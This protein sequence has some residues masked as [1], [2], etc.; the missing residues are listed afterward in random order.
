MSGPF[1]MKGSPMKRNFGIGSPM[2]DEKEDKIAAK[3]AK[4]IAA[5][6]KKQAEINAKNAELKAAGIRI[7]YS[8]SQLD[9]QAKRD[10][11]STIVKNPSL[12]EYKYGD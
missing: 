2:K 3:D 9:E 7:G 11:T 8:Q 1:K 5:R 10:S 12:H 4:I 6:K